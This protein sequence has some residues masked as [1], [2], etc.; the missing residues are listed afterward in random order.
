M[1]Y[2]PVQTFKSRTLH[3]PFAEKR[4][5]SVILSETKNLCIWRHKQMRGFF[6][7]FAQ[8]CLRLL[9]MKCRLSFLTN[10]YKKRWQNYLLQFGFLECKDTALGKIGTFASK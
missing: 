10:Y 6:L 5:A 4:S 2:A 7:R 8:D 9:R 3:Q 1:K